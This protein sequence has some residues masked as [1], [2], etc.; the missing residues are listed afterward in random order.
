MISPSGACVVVC[1]GWVVT[2]QQRSKSVTVVVGHVLMNI[3]MG[4]GVVVVV[5]ISSEI[6]DIISLSK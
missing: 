3:S 1:R 6:G 2:T 4:L 5:I